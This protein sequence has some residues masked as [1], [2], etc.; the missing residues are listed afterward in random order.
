MSDSLPKS[1]DDVRGQEKIDHIL[2][3][4]EQLRKWYNR[5]LT[6]GPISLP[7]YSAAHVQL[8]MVSIVCFLC[9]GM[10]NALQGLGGGGQVETAT[11]NK[12]NLT[13]SAVSIIGFFYGAVCNWIGV[14]K[15]MSLG[16]IGYSVY[17][18]SFLCYN[19]TKNSGFVIF[20]GAL[21]GACCNCLWAA[22][23]AVMVSYPEEGSKGRYIAIFWVIFNLGAVIGSIIPLA[24]N[25]H[26]DQG[27]VGDGTYA[28]FIVLMF[29]GAVLALCLL[30]ADKVRRSDG[31][32]IIVQKNPTIKS[33]LTGF[34]RVFKTD[35]KIVI[36]FPMFFSSNFFYTYQF[37]DVNAAYYTTRTRAL[38]NLLYWLCQMIFAFA[39]GVLLDMKWFN[40]RNRARIGYV[41]LYILTLAIWGGGLAFQLPY[42]R[43]SAALPSFH[44]TDWT[45]SGYVGGMFLYIFYGGYDACYQTFCYWLMGSITNNSRKAALFVGM[46]KGVQAMGG[47]VIY[48][49]DWKNTK[50][51]AN[52]GACWGLLVFSLT[53]AFPMAFFKVIET[54]TV[55]HDLEFSNETMADLIPDDDIAKRKFSEEV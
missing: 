36:L 7:P 27:P 55:E 17:A 33:E 8:L 41:T 2:L 21:L 14:D 49:M 32:K 37:N 47:M 52:F 12:A 23:G 29:L 42:T 30:P 26:K 24:N 53:L 39:F 38:N 16:G 11:A 28:A 1:L 50:Y 35:P 3:E 19:H 34:F 51:M 44:R 43:A 40:R 45:D 13:L 6:I 15:T 18:A 54:T 31:T 46:Y 10:F 4:N 25:I 5:R 9:P 48:I 22:E 20:A